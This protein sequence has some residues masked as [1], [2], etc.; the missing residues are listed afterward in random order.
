MAEE[1]TLKIEFV[2]NGK[3][4]F[5]AIDLDYPLQI[6]GEPLVAITVRRLTGGEVAEVQAKIEEHGFQ[7]EP[8]MEAFTDQPQEVI[9]HLD[10]DDRDKLEATVLDFLPVK[11]RNALE[12]IRAD[13]EAMLQARME[14]AAEEQTQDK[15][16][17]GAA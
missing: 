9:D 6:N 12:S 7:F 13:M 2:D 8:L 10:Q 16:S 17:P 11:M 3:P 1:T 15:S 5:K 4:R 14:A